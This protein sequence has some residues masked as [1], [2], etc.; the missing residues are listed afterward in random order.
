MSDQVPRDALIHDLAIVLAGA[1]HPSAELGPA[2]RLAAR[3]MQDVLGIADGETVKGIEK[4]LNAVLVDGMTPVTEPRR[5][6]Q[7]RLPVAL[8]G[9]VIATMDF[10]RA[11]YTVPW[12]M[13]SDMQGRL[14]LHPDYDTTTAPHGTMSMRVELREDGYRVWPVRGHAYRPRAEPGYYGTPSRPFIPVAV[15]EGAPDGGGQR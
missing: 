8:T 7:A 1:L 9:S 6:G 10:G 2:P 14:W 11:C 12:A 13:W 5:N 15:I 3:R 4:R